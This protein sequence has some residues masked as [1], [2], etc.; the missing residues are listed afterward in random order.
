M[1]VEVGV[2]TLIEGV[3]HTRNYA[4]SKWV[5]VLTCNLVKAAAVIYANTHLAIGVTQKELANRAH[6]VW[7]E[8]NRPPLHI[9]NVG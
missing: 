6:S 4:S 1:G 3:I 8:I 2:F 7:V 5:G 9:L